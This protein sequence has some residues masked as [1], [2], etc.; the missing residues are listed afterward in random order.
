MHFTTYASYDMS[1]R[2]ERL[3][4]LLQRLEAASPSASAEEAFGLLV[5]TLNQV[6]DEMS[7]VAF[8]PDY[9]LDDGRMYPPKDDARREV[10]GR[11]D[12]QRFRS[13]KHNIYISDDGALR[14]EEVKGS[15]CLLNK[16]AKS[17]RTIKL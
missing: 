7:G 14:I 10:D 15:K 2:G 3:I 8:D 17:G 16:P 9:P 12:L 6:E 1:T 5:T 13:R 11:P 4:E